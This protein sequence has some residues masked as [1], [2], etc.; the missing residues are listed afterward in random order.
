[1]FGCLILMFL[2]GC[3]HNSKE[4]T[5]SSSFVDITHT[6]DTTNVVSETAYGATINSVSDTRINVTINT[7]PKDSDTIFTDDY[8]LVVP[9][10]SATIV[11]VD[12][13]MVDKTELTKGALIDLQIKDPA[14]TTMSIPP[15]LAGNSLDKIIVK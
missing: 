11:D 10:E 1:M 2:S 3:G 12:G 13:N 9:I 8:E 15:I 5:D 4:V 7:V 6:S 14:I